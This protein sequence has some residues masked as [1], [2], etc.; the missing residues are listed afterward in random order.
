M[1]VWGGERRTLEVQV[2][3]LRMVRYGLTLHELTTI[4]RESTGAVAGATIPAGP[5]QAL[6]RGVFWPS[7]PEELRAVALRGAGA[8][9]DGELMPLR[10]SDVATVAEHHEPRIGAATRDGAGECVY[11][12][13]Q[14]ARDEN[15]L[16][17]MGRLHD[18]LPALFVHLGAT[19]CEGSPGAGFACAHGNIPAILLDD[20]DPDVDVVAVDVASLFSGS[21][22]DAP[23]GEADSISGCM[24]FGGIR[25]ARRSS[26][27]SG[28]RSRGAAPR[29]RRS[30]S[31]GVERRGVYIRHE[32]SFVSEPRSRG[33]VR[34][35]GGR[36]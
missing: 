19:S 15:A 25:S 3:P 7:R 26:S 16:S 1:N 27:G 14:M 20:F 5:G 33:G 31:V 6:L 18:A 9:E 11:L 35:H 30:C 8:G 24:S 12:M 10:L 34:R 17:L 2:D 21:D 28:W 36:L 23:V 13:V 32:R 22:L 29:R 4:L